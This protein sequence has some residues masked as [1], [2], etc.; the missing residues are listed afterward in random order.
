MPRPR[1][2]PLAKKLLFA[3][4]PLVVVLLVLTVG[5]RALERAGLVSTVRDGDRVLYLTPDYLRVIQTP[6]GERVQLMD[7]Q[8]PEVVQASMAQPKPQDVFRI[9]VV[10]R[11]FIRGEHYRGADEG[12][13]GYGSIPAW[14]QALLDHRYPSQRFEVINAGGSAQSSYAVRDSV[15]A[16]LQVEPDLVLVA[17]GANEGSA[18]PTAYNQ[19][20][21]SWVLYRA[22]KKGLLGE[23]PVEERPMLQPQDLGAEELLGR[24]RDNLKLI[25]RAGH[26]A[27][28][29]MAWV[30]LPVNLLG[31][32]R[33]FELGQGSE[34]WR[35]GQQLCSQAR[36]GEALERI[37]QGQDTVEAMVS[38]AACLMEV[39]EHELAAEILGAAIE[40]DPRGT[41]RPSFNDQVR[42]I[43][44]TRY[45]PLVDLE[46]ELNA[47][48]P[49][50]LA[51]DLY[52]WDHLHLTSEGYL[53]AAGQVVETLGDAGLLPTGAGEP[54]E[55][56]SLE[57]LLEENGWVELHAQMVAV[58]R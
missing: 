13:G 25:A 3:A 32:G 42:R 16:L 52:F 14:M 53:W 31:Y 12:L 40:L 29:P 33:R 7:A 48:A 28:V 4:V 9:V 50:G 57:Q 24:Y 34:T 21:H 26:N 5:L 44:A 17:S 49:H 1:P 45:A 58:G 55:D 43:A 37:A 51:G 36:Y 54:L 47:L 6:D 11:S 41:A 35:A 30:A 18:P 20:L 19:A 23:I 38:S 46:A 22:M 27:Q 15:D 2:L 39:G 56:P 8:Y 10:G